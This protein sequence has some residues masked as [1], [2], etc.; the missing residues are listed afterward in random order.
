MSDF[1]VAGDPMTTDK[2]HY[3]PIENVRFQ[4]LVG[5][6]YKKRTPRIVRGRDVPL[7]LGW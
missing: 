1:S 6:N 7:R 5:K 4:P 3:K 2:L